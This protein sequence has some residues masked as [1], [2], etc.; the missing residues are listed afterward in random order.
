MKSA[1]AAII[2]KIFKN[3]RKFLLISGRSAVS[4]GAY[5]QINIKDVTKIRIILLLDKGKFILK[6]TFP[7]KNN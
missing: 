3:P 6:K 2:E 7:K 4:A 5:K 1:D